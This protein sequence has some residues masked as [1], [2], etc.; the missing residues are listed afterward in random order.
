MGRSRIRQ[1]IRDQNTKR[2]DERARNKSRKEDCR[3]I[4]ENVPSVYC[5]AVLSDYN[6]FKCI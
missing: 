2:I 5:V 4:H 3:K 6:T 1:L